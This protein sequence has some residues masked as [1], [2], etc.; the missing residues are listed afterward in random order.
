VIS[1][2][3]IDVVGQTLVTRGSKQFLH[4]GDLRLP[5]TPPD[6]DDDTGMFALRTQRE[7][8]VAVT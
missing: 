7:D 1:S 5:S 8:I 4:G 2:S 6:K 3:D